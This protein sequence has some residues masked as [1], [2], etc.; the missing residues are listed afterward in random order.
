[1]LNIIACMAKN[2]VIGRNGKIPWRLPP[3]LKRFRSLTMGHRVVMG[4]VTWED[5]KA[6]P[7][8]NII[9]LSSTLELTEALTWGVEIAK[10]LEECLRLCEDNAFIAGGEK[11]YRAFLPLVSRMYLTFI[12]H[13]RQGDAHFPE[14]DASEWETVEAARLD[15]FSF[16]TLERTH[17][18]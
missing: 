9:V 2:R 15:T 18:N 3:D 8:R 1:M 7:G 11:V 5:V 13:D 10:D 4:R 12:H 6:L 14:F 16:I 17:A